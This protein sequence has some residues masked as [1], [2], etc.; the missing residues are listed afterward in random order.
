MATSALQEVDRQQ[1]ADK[2]EIAQLKTQVTTLETQMAAVLLRLQALE[3][4]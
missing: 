1:Q 4:P 2:T 3:N